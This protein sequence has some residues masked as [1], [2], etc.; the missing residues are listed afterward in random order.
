MHGLV[1][2]LKLLNLL[3]GLPISDHQSLTPETMAFT[4]PDRL[5]I[6]LILEFLKILLIR[7]LESDLALKC[8]YVELHLSYLKISLADTLSFLCNKRFKMAFFF[9]QLLLVFL[10]EL[11]SNLLYFCSLLLCKLKSEHLLHFLVNVMRGLCIINN[12]LLLH[13][14]SLRCQFLVEF[15]LFGVLDNFSLK[16]NLLFKASD[17]LAK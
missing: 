11:V 6:K 7:A 15:A 9:S 16:F 4:A 2:F 12:S 13:L 17:L 1:L 5:E 3:D 8:L 14:K 10:G